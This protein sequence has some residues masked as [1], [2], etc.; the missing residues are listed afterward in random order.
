[1][2]DYI[3]KANFYNLLTYNSIVTGQNEIAQKTETRCGC[4]TTPANPERPTRLVLDRVKKRGLLVGW[5]GGIGPQ[6]Y[7]FFLAMG[8][9][10][11]FNGKVINDRHFR[12]NTNLRLCCWRSWWQWQWW[13]RHSPEDEC[14]QRGRRRTQSSQPY[15]SS[16]GHLQTGPC[17]PRQNW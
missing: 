2:M 13:W 16:W 17:T 1:M 14:H 8:G 15:W 10:M 4:G 3:G 5:V 7:Q 12:P 11:L 6:G 9:C